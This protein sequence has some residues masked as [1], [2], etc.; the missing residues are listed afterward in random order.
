VT[1]GF[2]EAVEGRG[3][4]P[5]LRQRIGR[6]GMRAV[7]KKRRRGRRGGLRRTRKRGVLQRALEF[8]EIRSPMGDEF[9]GLAV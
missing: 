4:G 5:S 6:G 1:I 3:Q 7:L 2:G 8:P 9:W